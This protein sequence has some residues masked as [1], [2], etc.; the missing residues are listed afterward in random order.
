MT[1]FDQFLADRAVA[2]GINLLRFSSGVQKKIL[3]I[4]DRMSSEL[5]A[6]ILDDRLTAAA[7]A[8]MEALLT[9]TNGIIERYY[10]DISGQA[11]LKL[12]G[13]ARTEPQVWRQAFGQASHVLG[14]NLDIVMPPPA[15][16]E[17]LASDVLIQK[18]PSAAWWQQQGR[19]SVWRF[20]NEV[21]QGIAQGE[22]NEDIVRRITGNKRTGAPGALDI[23]KTDARRL[24]QASVQTVA[25]AARVL[26]F[27]RNKDVLDGIQQL[28]TLD[29]HT[30]PICIAYSGAQWDMNYE[31]IN[32]TKLPYNNP[33]G[34]P[35]CPRHW[36]C[37]STII[38]LT[39]SFADMGIDLPEFEP[40]TRASEGGQ[41]AAS[42]TMADWLKTRTEAQ[43]DEQLGK[44]RA[45]LYRRGVITLQQLL[46]Q[47]GNPLSLKQLQAIYE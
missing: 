3:A 8:R 31:P 46:D 6:R 36:G 38:P 33:D 21:R 37:R 14:V 17:T 4:L 18:A 30:T 44:G 27:Q 29:G 2:H 7:R 5:S 12:A 19:Y 41:V 1:W 23:S 22:T 16:L 39:K 24:V 9:D 13:L 45:D 26:T 40:T 34:S 11:A 15:M 10:A 43:L 20:G 42:T 35:G 47:S 32:G 28:S 25:N